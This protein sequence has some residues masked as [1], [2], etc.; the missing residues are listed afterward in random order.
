MILCDR[1]KKQIRAYRLKIDDMHICKECFVDLRLWIKEGK[2][3]KTEQH[4]I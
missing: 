2:N 3:L 4:K 1:C